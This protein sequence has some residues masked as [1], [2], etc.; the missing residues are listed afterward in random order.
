MG[1]QPNLGTSQPQ[2]ATDIEVP[3]SAVYVD[4]WAL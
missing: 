2:D 3:N 1:E 4:Y